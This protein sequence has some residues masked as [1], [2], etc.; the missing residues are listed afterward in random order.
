[1]FLGS[2]EIIILGAILLVVVLSITRQPKAA[3]LLTGLG[4]VMLL[5]AFVLLS[6]RFAFQSM[7]ASSIHSRH[8]T[9]PVKISDEIG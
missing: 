5:L 1:M 4:L 3:T 6:T 9:V 7:P 8:S 2:I